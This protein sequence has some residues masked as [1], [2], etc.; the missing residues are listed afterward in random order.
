MAARIGLMVRRRLR[1]EIAGRCRTMCS[2]APRSAVFS[3]PDVQSL[4]KKMTGLNL[5][6]IFKPKKQEL[7]PPTYKL[8]TEAQYQETIQKVATS[9]EKFL[10]MPPVLSVRQP[11]NEV[12]ADDEILRDIE[13]AKY[14]FTDISYSTPHRERFIVVREPSGVLR[15]ATWEERDRMIQVYFA[16]EGRKLVPPPIF[17]EENMQAMFQQDRHEEL[18]NRCLT[19]FDPDSAEY[20]RVHQQTYGN[21]DQYG[22]YDLL[23]STRHFGGMA[24]HLCCTK[25]IDGLL[26]DMIQRDLIEDSVRLIQL[27]N[28]LHSD[29]DCARKSL[30]LEG[31][32]LLKIFVKTEAQKP[33]Y[34]ELALQAYQEAA[35]DARSS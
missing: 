28:L 35:S 16:R 29:T 21:I 18:L 31:A 34:I 27:Y 10:E 26:I 11:I 24:W 14:V 19:Q 32:E 22:K 7:S 17:R 1:S 8:L 25:K 20:I 6:K 23:R 4:L 33:G 5:E 12:L 13:T 3:D 15:K 9:A 2:G 30:G